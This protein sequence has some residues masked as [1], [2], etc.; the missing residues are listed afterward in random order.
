MFA[1]RLARRRRCWGSPTW[2]RWWWRCRKCPRLV[3]TSPFPCKCLLRHPAPEPCAPRWQRRS[4]AGRS[5]RALVASHGSAFPPQQYLSCTG[6]SPLPVHAH[7]CSR[8]PHALIRTDEGADICLIVKD[9]KEMKAAL[10]KKPVP[11][12]SKVRPRLQRAPQAAPSCRC[13]SFDGS[14]CLMSV[15]CCLPLR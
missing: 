11:G 3:G 7:L 14:T 15:A 4:G 5:V 6:C 9:S 12:V 10:E 1:R 13:S 2:S 8:I